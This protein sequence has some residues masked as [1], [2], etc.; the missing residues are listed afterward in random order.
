MRYSMK[1]LILIVLAFIVL[2]LVTNA[3]AAT[4][5]GT[6]MK[7]EGACTGIL[8]D[9]TPVSFNYYSDFN[10]CGDTSKSAVTFTSGIEGLFT[11]ERV[12][13][14]KDVH[15]Y[16]QHRLTF[17][18][19]TGNTDGTLQYTDSEGTKQNVQ[20]QCDIRDYEYAESVNC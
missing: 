2:N 17:A 11:G 4:E 20:V 9:G 5:S 15:T 10:G 14:E 8:V 19:S 1:H 6:E 18:N 13:G 12:L 16:P 7:L 3:K